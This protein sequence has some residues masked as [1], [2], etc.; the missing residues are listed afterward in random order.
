MP[1][2][3]APTTCAD[4]MPSA[5]SSPTVSRAMSLERIRRPHRQAQAR[6]NHRAD[7][8][9]L[10]EVVHLLRQAAIAVV[11]SHD[12]EAALHQH[13]AER[14]GPAHELHPQAHD[15]QHDRGALV[16]ERLVFQRDSVCDDARHGL[17]S[18]LDVAWSQG[19]LHF[20]SPAALKCR[21][22]HPE[23]SMADPVLADRPKSRSLK[24]LRALLPFLRPLPRHAAARARRAAGRGRRD[25]RAA[26]GAALP[27]RRGHGRAAA[28]RRS[29]ATSSLFLGGRRH[30]RRVRGAALLPRQLARR[31]RRGR[32]ARGGV[33]AGDPDGPGLLRGHAHRRSAVATDRRHDARAV[34]RRREPL[35]HA[36]L[37]DLGRRQPRDARGHQPQAHRASSSC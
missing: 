26:R 5:S 37:R 3:E 19:L 31:A 2:I 23:V 1:P 18:H 21:F 12:A 27:D 35:D 8:V 22:R 33:R 15:Q 4:R 29:T 14:V 13:L 36:A 11:E 6:A 16:P 17:G 10:A 24:P 20:S 25:A 30:L 28:R 7:Q 34:D 32:P 9:R